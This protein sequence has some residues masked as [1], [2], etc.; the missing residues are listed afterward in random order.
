MPHII[1]VTC[2]IAMC[3]GCVGDS[4]DKRVNALTAE[5][6]VERAHLRAGGQFWSQP[7]SLTLK[8]HGIFYQGQDTFLHETHNMYRV[9]EATKENAHAANGKVRIESFRNGEPII[10][11]SFDGRN[12]YD[13]NG[14]Q[15]RSDADKRWASNFGYGVIRHAFDKGYALALEGTDT[16]K[17]KPTHTVK[18]IDP[19]D[20]ETNF[21]ITQDSFDIV[22]V[23]F[24][25][26]RGHHHRLYS[27]FFKKEK[28]NWNQ[29]G[30]VEL[31]YNDVKANEIIWEDFEVNANL[32]DELFIIGK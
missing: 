7:I 18:L 16:I 26:P 3:L 13:Q 12:T 5:Q 21:D 29:A 32:K 8:G 15:E 2:F 10:L 9:Y 25:T 14:K 4:D 22:K 28:F 19:N 6:I 27:K 31:Y 11:L 30:L 1:V 23:A 17:G 24:E 20:G